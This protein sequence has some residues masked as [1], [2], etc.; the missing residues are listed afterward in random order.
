MGPDLQM[1]T[2][3]SR[4]IESQHIRLRADFRNLGSSWQH[5]KKKGGRQIGAMTKHDERVE[6]HRV[7]SRHVQPHDAFYKAL[8]DT[9]TE[10]IS[11]FWN[12]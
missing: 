6:A 2:C 10:E 5:E 12:F 3:H 7:P 9:F 8:S 1:H 4:V 11:W